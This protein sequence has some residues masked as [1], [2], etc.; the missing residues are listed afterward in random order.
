MVEVKRWWREYNPVKFIEITQY[1][2]GGVCRHTN[3]NQ[4]IAIVCRQ[5]LFRFLYS[6]VHTDIGESNECLL[7]NAG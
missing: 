4:T 2:N 6:K 5:N 3:G 7:D 1:L